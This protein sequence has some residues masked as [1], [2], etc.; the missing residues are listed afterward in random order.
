MDRKTTLHKRAPIVFVF[1]RSAAI[2]RLFRAGR[3]ASARTIPPG[4]QAESSAFVESSERSAERSS[5]SGI[6]ER[7]ERNRRREDSRETSG[8]SLP[9]SSPFLR[10][11]TVPLP[12][13]KR[14]AEGRAN[15]E[16]HGTETGGADLPVRPGTACSSLLRRRRSRGKKLELR[17]AGFPSLTSRYFDVTILIYLFIFLLFLRDYYYCLI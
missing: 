5:A 13:N 9:A 16:E 8:S 12:R 1:A 11:G 15:R 6:G 7:R 14:S 17:R 4:E 2:L 10:D 3:T